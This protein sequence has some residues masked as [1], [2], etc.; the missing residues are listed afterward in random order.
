[1]S[2]S[3]EGWSGVFVWKPGIEGIV[4]IRET[5]CLFFDEVLSTIGRFLIGSI[6]KADQ[7]L[8]VAACHIAAGVYICFF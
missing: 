5:I 2:L 8:K 6:D 3:K 1:M 4:G 7:S